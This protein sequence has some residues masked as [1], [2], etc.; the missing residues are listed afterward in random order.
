MS[1][2]LQGKTAIVTGAARGIGL[3]I[4]ERLASDGA[5]LVLSDLDAEA[6]ASAG[7]KLAAATGKEGDGRRR[8]SVLAD[9]LQE[10]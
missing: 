5:Q 6:L 7:D 9:C 3:A 10:S 1:G 4:A 2:K 8:R